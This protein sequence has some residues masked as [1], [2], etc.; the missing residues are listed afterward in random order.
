MKDEY[1]FYISIEKYNHDSK[2]YERI[3]SHEQVLFNE[4]EWTGI[5]TMSIEDFQKWLQEHIMIR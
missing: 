5:L 4:D 1:R 2:K 3:Y